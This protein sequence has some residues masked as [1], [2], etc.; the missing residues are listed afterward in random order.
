[1]FISELYVEKFRLFSKNTFKLG[2][3]IT[4]ITGFNATGKSMVLFISLKEQL[5][6]YTLLS[7]IAKRF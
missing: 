7:L 1:M 4:A 5:Y 2:K 3:Y 6:L